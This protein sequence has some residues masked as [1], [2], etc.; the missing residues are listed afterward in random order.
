MDINKI[1]IHCMNETEGMKGSPCPKCGRIL[2]QMGEVTHQLKPYTILQGKYLVGDVLGEGGF[3]I[4]YIGFDLNL[5]MKVAIKEFYP[6]GYAVRESANTSQLTVYA[7]QNAD[8]VYKWRENF[9]KEARSL[10]KCSYLSGVVGV[11]DFFQENNTAYI[12]L[13]YLEGM[14]LKAYAKSL[15]GRIG[16]QS[17]LPALE[18]VMAALGEVHRQG[19]IH[20][21]ISPDNIMLLPGGQMKLLDFGAA[22]DYTAGDEKSLSVMLKPG[23][24]PEE[25]YRS[26]GKQGPW[27]DIYAFAGTIY[28]CLTGVTPPEAMERMRMDELRRPN[29][30]GAG[31]EPSQ[32]EAL[33]KAMS[34]FAEGR[35]QTMEE[36]RSALYA[37][38]A[39]SGAAWAAQ[40]VAGQPTEMSTGQQAV[41]QGQAT[42][43][44]YGQATTG[45]PTGMPMNQTG[46]T[47]EAYM[48]QS[49]QGGY[50]QA[51][52]A[53]GPSRPGLQELI[54]KLTGEYRNI[55]IG[56][57]AGL[58]VIFVAVLIMRVL[59]GREDSAQMASNTGGQPET[60]AVETVEE[61]V[62]E[63]TEPSSVE[64]TAQPE[65]TPQPES[66]PAEEAVD[67][68]T[69]LEA[70]QGYFEEQYYEG[71]C[72]LIY[73]DE[74]EVPE[75]A[76][77]WGDLGS[78]VLWYRDGEVIDWAHKASLP[79]DAMNYGGMM[80]SYQE[81]GRKVLIQT[82]YDNTVTA[83]IYEFSEDD[84]SQPMRVG[85]K[86]Y[87]DLS[88]YLAY[89]NDFGSFSV[90]WD[91]QY[92]NVWEAYAALQEMGAASVYDSKDATVGFVFGIYNSVQENYQIAA[93]EQSP[94]GWYDSGVSD[95]S[96]CY[97]LFLYDN[98]TC[99]TNPV[100][101]AYGTN[102]QTIRFTGSAG[103]ELLFSLSRRTDNDTIAGMTDY[104]YEAEFDSLR[105]ATKLVNSSAE[106]HGRVIV[107]GYAS[108][109]DKIVYDL[110]KVDPQYIMHMVV[111]FPA[112]TGEEDKNLKDYVTECIYRMCRFSGNTEELRNYEEYCAAMGGA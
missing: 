81:S 103:S 55:L 8:S 34:V 49:G 7:G 30:L 109:R 97:P 40:P 24:A 79:A 58:V 84:L 80:V 106:D 18:P 77:H 78:G 11:R 65:P 87:D 71:S 10:G 73:L 105:E 22:R 61:S 44:G 52:Q 75:Y 21:D 108:A 89:Q 6:N 112:Y 17:L 96:F 63:A 88:S 54:K 9:L 25:Q 41:P 38:G 5:E 107:T 13:E 66:S 76:Y 100:E 46:M 48:A 68:E 4:T 29:E 14:T 37:K 15:G 27:S 51:G 72:S 111:T 42:G 101:N 110:V 67:I 53:S 47:Q 91:P 98:V 102:V 1:C 57:A 33:L 2:G 16:A 86:E 35:Y 39:A 82:R 59:R 62:P 26:K 12:V 28:K 69:V 90:G 94:Y 64:P 74:D 92:G 83:E 43:G 36:F 31:L 50:T 93:Y 19:L 56:A 20:R 99:D 45:Q 23:Y 32:E 70:Y 3:G 95:F 85:Y 60:G 104:I